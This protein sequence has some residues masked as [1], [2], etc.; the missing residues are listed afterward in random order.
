LGIVVIVMFNKMLVLVFELM[1]PEFQKLDSNEIRFP[2]NFE[3]PQN[4]FMKS[5]NFFIFAVQCVQRENIHN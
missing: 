5:A 1:S 3:N 2:F 4:I